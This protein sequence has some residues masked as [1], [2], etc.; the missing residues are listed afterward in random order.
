LSSLGLY[1]HTVRHLRPIQIAARAW[2]RLHRPSPDLRA[3]PETRSMSGQYQDPISP[4][5]SLLG[6]DQFRF[7]NVERRCA[8][9]GDWCATDATKLWIYHLHYFDDLNARDA[10]A[11]VT[12]HENLLAR[13]VAEN[14]PGQGDGWDPYPVSRRIVNCVKWAARGNVVPPSF[15]ASL[16]VQ[17]RWLTHRLEY[18]ILGNHLL[19]NAKALLHAGLYFDGAEAERWCARAMHIL[20]GQ[21]REQVLADGGHVELSTMYQAAI[22]EDLL[23]L[24]NLLRAYGMQAPLSWIEA[25]TRMRSWLQ[26]MSH[27]DGKI[28]F[29]NDAAFGVAPTFADLEAYANRLG[30]PVLPDES[31]SVVVLEPSGYVRIRAG[32]AYLLCDCAPVGADHLPGHAHADSLSFELS[33]AG[34]RIFVN[35]GTSQ[36]GTDAERQRQRGTAAHNTVVVDEKDSSEVWAGFRV[37]RRA[38]IACRPITTIPPAVVI[39]ASHDGYRRLPGRNEH[40]R[41]WTVDDCSLCIEDEITGKFATAAAFLHIHPEFDARVASANEIVL[42]SSDDVSV[43]VTFAGAM[44]VELLPGTWHPGFGVEIANRCIVARFSG[45]TLTTCIFWAAVQ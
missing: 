31:A 17:T 21:L 26:V 23:D 43:R 33:V 11:R 36:Y 24:V 40:R 4:A 25:T 13:W 30:L 10:A 38:H 6:P 15:R 1:F 45:A 37:A 8:A 3:A 7:L 34:R 9:A 2:F 19:T 35:S 44:A 39:E 20:T 18:H 32:S 12:W 16:A 28:A 41:R 22:L 5:P 14:P 29:F 42:N 27:P